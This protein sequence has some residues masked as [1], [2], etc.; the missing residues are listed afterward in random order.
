MDKILAMVK[1]KDSNWKSIK[2]TFETS[3]WTYESKIMVEELQELSNEG[4]QETHL[5]IL[6]LGR[7]K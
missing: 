3:Q 2:M 1:G 6:S 7:D 5:E 4:N